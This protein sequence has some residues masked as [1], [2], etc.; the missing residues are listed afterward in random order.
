MCILHEF[1]EIF[2]LVKIW[3]LSDKSFDLKIGKEEFFE[4][5]QELTQGICQEMRSDL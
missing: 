1:I 5:S 4:N 3:F 2:W